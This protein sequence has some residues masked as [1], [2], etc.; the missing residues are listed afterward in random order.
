[1]KKTQFY[2]TVSVT[3]RQIS[4]SLIGYRLLLILDNIS[5]DF[6]VK[7]KLFY[8]EVCDLKDKSMSEAR[9][10]DGRTNLADQKD[11]LFKKPFTVRG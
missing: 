6:D 1:M 4:C 11:L 3:R 2:E 8:E 9:A 5:V 10:F 7:K